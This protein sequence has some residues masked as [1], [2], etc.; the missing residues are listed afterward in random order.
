[1]NT[2]Y[3]LTDLE[4][5]ERETTKEIIN[6][7]VLTPDTILEERVSI[8]ES[9]VDQLLKIFNKFSACVDLPGY[10]YHIESRVDIMLSNFKSLVSII[11]DNLPNEDVKP[12]QQKE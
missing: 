3:S 9:K 11:K 2:E 8:L 1:M 6:D 4:Y 12:L 5:L 10:D 7:N